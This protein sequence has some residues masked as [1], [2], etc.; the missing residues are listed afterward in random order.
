MDDVQSTGVEAAGRAMVPFRHRRGGI[1]VSL[2]QDFGDKAGHGDDGIGP[3]KQVGPA[4][5]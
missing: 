1:A 5:E 4:E 2:A 3:G